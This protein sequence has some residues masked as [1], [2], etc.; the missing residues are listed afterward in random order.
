MANYKPTITKPFLSP[1][2]VESIYGISRQRLAT[3]RQKNKGPKYYTLPNKLYVYYAEDINQ[4]ITI[5]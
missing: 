3:W 5:N 1:S 2:D 4:Y